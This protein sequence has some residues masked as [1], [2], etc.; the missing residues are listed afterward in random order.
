MRIAINLVFLVSGEGGGIERHVRGLLRGLEAVGGDHEYVLFTSRNCT[1]TFP[2]GPTMREVVCDVSA[3]FR[4]AKIVWEQTVLP[5]QLRQHGIDVVLSPANIAPIVVGRP[6]VL[7]MHD[8]IPFKRPE[9]FTTVERVA[10]KTLFSLSARSCDAILTVSESSKRDIAE[11]FGVSLSKI[12]VVPG[13]T[14]PKFRPI[15]ITD[16]V[17]ASL[18]RARIPDR[19]LL[20]VA[21]SR[22]Y[23][24]VEG[25][26]RAFHQLAERIPHSLVITGL[27][28][29][30]S[31]EI[32]RLVVGLGLVDRVVFS[33]FLD[34]ELLPA[35]YSAADVFVF[36]SF[37]EGFGLP[38]IE[39]MAC[40]TAVAAS[41]RT[42][43]PEAVGDAG[44][45]FDPDS[46]QEMSEAMHSILSNDTLRAELVQKGL[47]RAKQLSWETTARRTLAVL[48][49]VA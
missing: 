1:G 39:A 14:D 32:E 45:L 36:P 34:D 21:A 31:P 40:G 28:G 37:Y 38:V 2:L 26:V 13:A 3:K 22:A 19:Y 17:R 27:A 15:E 42:S 7:I 29:R 11:L 41:N 12:R 44:L 47:A 10:Q 18:R 43:I 4:P 23:K 5:F 16:I 20:Y 24:N 46:T 30:A 48:S 25:L 8:V 9:I 6:S 33:G 35:L 49:E